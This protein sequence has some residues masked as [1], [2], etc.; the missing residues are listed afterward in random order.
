VLIPGYMSRKS[1]SDRTLHPQ[2]ARPS[3]TLVSSASLRAY[4]GSHSL[5]LGVPSDSG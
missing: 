2:F 4:P 1:A 3:S 5:L